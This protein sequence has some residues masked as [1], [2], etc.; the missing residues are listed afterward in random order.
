MLLNNRQAGNFAASNI[1]HAIDED[2]LHTLAYIL[3]NG[4]D[5]GDGNYRLTDSIEI[6]CSEKEAG[7]GWLI[8]CSLL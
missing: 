5:N 7:V 6:A 4:L 8:V 3:T 1:Y 2:Y